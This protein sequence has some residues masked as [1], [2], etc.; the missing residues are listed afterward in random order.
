MQHI[1]AANHQQM[2]Q[3]AAIYIAGQV[4]AKPDS[5]LGFATG[6]SPQDTYKELIR[7]HKEGLDFS[8]VKTFNLDEYYGV[9]KTD[10][11][12]YYK[13]MY[14]NL[15]DHINIGRD[16]IHLPDG[17]VDDPDAECLRYE[18]MI[19]EA[20][21]VDLQLLG[22]GHNGHI[23]FNEPADFFPGITNHIKLTDST[24]DANSRFYATREEVPKTA[25]S[26]GIGTIMKAKRVILIASGAEKAEILEKAIYGP[27][28]P[29][30]PASILQFH[31][32]VTFITA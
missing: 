21:G 1:K 9:P 23:G 8:S 17:T 12:S 24:I 14:D 27:V 30:V 7:L 3:L 2:S 18:E 5:V 6:S 26:M 25:L 31:P 28:T 11:N 16:N 19:K 13:F 4:L 15:F 20:G 10:P 32:D 22:I 29:Q